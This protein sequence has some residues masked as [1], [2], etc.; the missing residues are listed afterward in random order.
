[1]AGTSRTGG[2]RRW[3]LQLGGQSSQ[4]TSSPY[5]LPP[6]T[7]PPSIVDP[8]ESSSAPAPQFQA[9]QPAVLRRPNIELP[10]R[11]KVSPI[12]VPAPKKKRD[13]GPQYEFSTEPEICTSPSWSDFGGRS[14][15][16]DKKKAEKERK[17]L[18]KKL[19]RENE[20]EEKAL[21]ASKRLSKMPPLAKLG[22]GMAPVI[23]ER[24]S[25]SSEQ[26]TE[27]T[28]S[29]STSIDFSLPSPSSKVVSLNSSA[30]S[31]EPA[32]QKPLQQTPPA[33]ICEPTPPSTRP[34]SSVDIS[35]T[36][37]PSTSQD[38]NPHN[39]Y[40]SNHPAA[41]MRAHVA[42]SRSTWAA[43]RRTFSDQPGRPLG[44]CFFIC[45][46]CLRWHDL[47][48]DIFEKIFTRKVSDPV[49]DKSDNGSIAHH[50]ADGTSSISSGKQK[51]AVETT[52]PTYPCPWC[53]H[54]MN[55][56]CCAAWTTIVYFHTRHH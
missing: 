26:P 49:T 28:T 29:S 30:S 55:A 7:L 8:A 22:K 17:E 42:G 38:P 37:P 27:P 13:D 15:K 12:Q 1:M 53:E 47:P 41:F 6:L 16:K 40:A 9:K 45:C 14:E 46:G 54:E 43:G 11:P 32:P 19:K 56:D 31:L 5:I 20:R 35:P 24:S 39:R 21:K 34:S 10:A 36:L 48:A 3:S 25:V 23:H 33:R 44:K 2:S 50:G 51:A 52:L 4:S 18:E